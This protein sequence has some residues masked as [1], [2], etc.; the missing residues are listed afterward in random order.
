MMKIN[1][2]A[3]KPAEPEQL[4]NVPRL[5]NACGQGSGFDSTKSANSGCRWTNPAT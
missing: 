5:I 2:L 3:G 4:I 1:S